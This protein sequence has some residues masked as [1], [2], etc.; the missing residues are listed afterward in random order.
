MLILLLRD[1]LPLFS[2]QDCCTL[3]LL[4]RAAMKGEVHSGHLLVA[5]HTGHLDDMTISIMKPSMKP[6]N[7]NVYLLLGR[8]GELA[9]IHAATCECAAG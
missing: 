8:D 1:T 6:G 9:H 5:I 4:V 2:T 3:T 7:Y